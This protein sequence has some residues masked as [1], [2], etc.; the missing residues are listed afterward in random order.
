MKLAVKAYVA[1]TRRRDPLIVPYLSGHYHFVYYG[2]DDSVLP[3]ADTMPNLPPHIAKDAR[4]TLG[5]FR[6]WE[7]HREMARR[8]LETDDERALFFEDDAVPNHPKWVHIVNETLKM[9]ASAFSVFS[10]HGRR[11]DCRNFIPSLC[12]GVDTRG[13]H[14]WVKKNLPRVTC[15]GALAYVLNRMSAGALATRDFDGTPIDVFLPNFGSFGCLV[16]SIFNHDRQ[17][18]SLVDHTRSKD[19]KKL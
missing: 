10:F 3:P 4:K 13:R 15:H 6:A 5:H 14:I 16:P 1:A 19:G 9:Q 17:Q 8:F 2:P 12:P 18:G 11:M 7:N